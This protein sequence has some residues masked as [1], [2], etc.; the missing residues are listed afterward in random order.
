MGRNSRT[1]IRRTLFGYRRSA[2]DE[3]LL[4]CDYTQ[5]RAE[6]NILSAEARIAELQAELGDLEREVSGRDRQ[7]AELQAEVA[8]LEDR[9]TDEGP[10][11][12]TDEVATILTAAHDAA[13]RIVQRARSVSDRMHQTN[14]RED[15]VRAD[16]T[17]LAAWRDE[18]LP[19]ISS[20]RTNMDEIRAELEEVAGRIMDALGP[21]EGLPAID[22]VVVP[23]DEAPEVVEVD[24]EDGD[25]DALRVIEPRPDRRGRAATRAGRPSGRSR[26]VEKLT[27]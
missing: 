25:L 15:R 18:A 19:I 3:L 21:L 17:R 6:S 7:L 4:E 12:V 13:A 10:S 9:T 27:G 24:E 5:R 26:S 22:D 2:V 23:E 1:G 16:A 11:F 8:R 14:R 20:V